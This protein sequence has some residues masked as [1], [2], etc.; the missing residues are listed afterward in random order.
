MTHDPSKLIWWLVSRA[1]GIVALVLISAA[2]LLGLTM[3]TRLLRR[4]GVGRILMGLHEHVALIA[5][6]AIALHG[7]ALLGD[8]WLRP[9]FGGILVPFAL[10]Y[11]PLFTGLG[12]LGGYLTAALALSYYARR[13]IGNKRW[14]KL[15][16]AILLAWLM[17]LVHTLGAGSDAGALWLRAVV[18]VPTIPI[19]FLAVLRFLPTRRETGQRLDAR[20]AVAATRRAALL[21]EAT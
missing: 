11:R 4:P 14:R 5:L 10:G 13:R 2:V 15:H 20:P 8:G 1:S 12:I 3:S 21:E 9:G 18:F 7:L 17:A 6:A 19:V 16:R